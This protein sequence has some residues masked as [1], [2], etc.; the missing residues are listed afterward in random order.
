[1]GPSNA[2]DGTGIML[3]SG[4]QELVKKLEP[5]LLKMTGNLMN[6]GEETGKAAGMKLI[7]NCF[8]VGFTAALADTLNL[9]TSLNIPANDVASLLE[10]WN[11]GNMVSARMKR[12]TAGSYNNPSWELSMARKDTGLFIDA[13][14]KAGRKLTI[15]PAIA[16]EMDSLIA[17]GHGNDDWTVLGKASAK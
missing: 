2:L 5:E 15:M 7:G 12:M 10:N 9:A 8:L 4:E 1:M 17:E 11:P 14:K 16:T 13:A 6:L 3:I